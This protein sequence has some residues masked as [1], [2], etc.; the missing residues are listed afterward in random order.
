MK[1]SYGIL[2]LAL[3]IFSITSVFAADEIQGPDVQEVNE[4]ISKLNSFSDKLTSVTEKP[5]NIPDNLKPI[6]KAV[7]RFEDEITVST[8]VISIMLL[9]LLVLF[10]T[11]MVQ[12]FSIF[13]PM[14]SAIIGIILTLTLSMTGVLK[15]TTIWLLNA[16]SHFSLLESIGA[17]WFLFAVLGIIIFTIII[18]KVLGTIKEIEEKKKAENIGFFL[19][20]R[21]AL[22]DTLTKTLTSIRGAVTKDDSLDNKKWRGWAD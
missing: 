14:T 12:I 22:T 3:L 18:L 21:I 6:V 13:S 7:F 20:T 11:N 1:K 9:I 16:G 19:G 10:F 15:S 4:S 2:V 17:G 8:L 5:I